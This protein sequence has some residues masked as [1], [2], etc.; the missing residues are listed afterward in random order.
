M[1][2]PE[3]KEKIQEEERLRYEAQQ[4]IKGQNMRIGCLGFIVLVIVLSI[5]IKLMQ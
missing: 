5:I 3:K 4:K 1:F 2:S